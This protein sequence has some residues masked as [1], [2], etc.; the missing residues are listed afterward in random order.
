[1]CIE[2]LTLR[3]NALAHA[4]VQIEIVIGVS[5]DCEYLEIFYATRN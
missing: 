1:V 3:T 2:R 4:L 5:I